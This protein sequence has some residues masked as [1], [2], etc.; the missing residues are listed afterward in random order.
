MI[1][2][3]YLKERCNRCR[4]LHTDCSG[5]VNIDN[6][7]IF[8][9]DRC[10]S[11][12]LRQGY[13]HWLRFCTISKSSGLPCIWSKW[14][15]IAVWCFSAL[16]ALMLWVFEWENMEFWV[17]LYLNTRGLLQLMSGKLVCTFL[18]ITIKTKDNGTVRCFCLFAYIYMIYKYILYTV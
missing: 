11:G 3:V 6:A 14:L 15:T 12:L 5:E 13:H 7:N 18:W 16:S 2:A 10:F 1:H 8:P 17:V 4:L 9:V